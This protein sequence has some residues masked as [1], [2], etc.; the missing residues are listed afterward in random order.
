MSEPN[1]PI[2]L[3]PNGGEVILGYEVTIRW[4]I[5]SPLNTD[6]RTVAYELYYTESF[7]P[8]KEPEWK[9]IAVVPATVSQYVWRFGNGIRSSNIRVAVRS[10][11]SKGQ[12]SRFTISANNFSIHRRRLETPTIFSPIDGERF[13][14]FID[15]ITDD[16]GIIGSYSER[17]FYQFYFSSVST[18]FTSTAIAQ[19][20]PIGQGAVRWE[21]VN[22]PPATDYVIQAFLADDDGN[23]SDSVFIRNIEVSH[24]GFF[25][26]DTMPPEASITI[27]NNDT[28]TR[29]RN[30]TVTV[31]TYDETTAVHA[32]QLKDANS[33][34]RPEPVADVTQY[35]LSKDDAVKTVQLLLQ[36]YGANRNNREIKRLFQTLTE[37]ESGAN[38]VD[39][40]VERTTS[41]I[42]GTVWVITS[43]PTN[44]LF[45]IQ[46]FPYLATVFDDEPTAVAVFNSFPYIGVKKTDSL[47]TLMRFN[48][49]ESV[50]VKEF[51]E[52][53]SVIN[54]MT[55]HNKKLFIGFENGIVYTFDGLN[56]VKLNGVL[57]PV[58][59]IVSDGSLLFLT[60]RNGTDVFV[61]NGTDFVSTG[62]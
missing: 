19:N 36:D 6:G 61:F 37:S 39:V 14:K 16:S 5:P 25:V 29:D 43:A 10:R 58:K 50:V 56:F 30:V 62:A 21:T 23:V 38:F 34:G 35:T 7:D 18:G 33:S 48:G 54:A 24:E 51:T 15:I 4:Q 28:F 8:L 3:F 32:M 55:T 47:G 53:D 12:R 2:L 20:V 40:A 52:A 57:N 45:K 27:N 42:P 9:Q 26:I 44:Y 11:N 1:F 13:D 60:E 17:S 22:L 46:S 59:T 41:T 31:V 49:Y